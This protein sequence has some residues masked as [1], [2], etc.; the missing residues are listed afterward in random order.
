MANKERGARWWNNSL[1]ALNGVLGDYLVNRGNELALPMSFYQDGKPLSL[2]RD[3]EEQLGR[4]LTDRV[5]V[6]VHG[7]CCHE[8]FWDFDRDGGSTSYGKMFSRDLGFTPFYVRYNTGLPILGN[9]ERLAVL[10]DEL[11]RVYPQPCREVLLL[12]HSMGGLVFREACRVGLKRSMA[13]V[14]QVSNC[15]C[16][17]SPLKGAP[18]EKL[19]SVSAKIMDLAGHP[20]THVVRDLINI[21]SQGIKDLCHGEDGSPKPETGAFLPEAG[22]F[23]VAGTLTQNPAHPVTLILGDSMVR[24]PSATARDSSGSAPA[25][26]NVRVFPG[27]GHMAL[28]HNMEVYQQIVSWIRPAPGLL[29][30]G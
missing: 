11:F 18:L 24:I 10:L 17:G 13:W 7:L 14:R 1:S 29:E 8:G 25:T 3:L 28:M 20:L 4:P 9:G 15:V 16:L 19:G 2:D 6:L 27:V 23:A 12:G 22:H 30:A 5:C 26:E 21:R